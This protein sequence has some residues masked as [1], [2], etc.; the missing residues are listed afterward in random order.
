MD[1]MRIMARRL[2]GAAAMFSAPLIVSLVLFAV[3]VAITIWSVFL[4]WE[5]MNQN[6]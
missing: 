5:D 2:D 6:G 4:G 1:S 3:G